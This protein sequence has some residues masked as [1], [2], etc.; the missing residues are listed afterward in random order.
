MS[1]SSLW[2][3]TKKNLK[4]LIRSKSSALIVIFA[5]LLIILILGLSYNTSAQYGLNIG[6]YSSSFTEDVTS[7]ISILEEEDFKV[8]KYETSV[9]EC[10]EDIKQGLV[11]TCVSLPESLNV[12]D[13][14]QKEV[15]FH[16][17]PSRVNLVWMI[18][19][20]VKTKFNLKSQEISKELAQNILTSFIS[21]KEGISEG[22]NNLNSIKEKALFASTSTQ[23]THDSL[24]DIDLSL[25]EDSISSDNVTLTKILKNIGESKDLIDNAISGI[26]GAGIEDDEVRNEIKS[27]LS[28]ADALLDELE[29]NE[30]T[31]IKDLISDFETKLSATQVKMT[32]ATSAIEGSSSDLDGVASKLQETVSAIDTLKESLAGI[33]TNLEEQ[34][35]TDAEIIV[36]PLTTKIERV[37]EKGT[38]LNYVFPTLLILVIMFTS[39]LLGTSL[40]MMEK[41]SP[42]FLRNF[43]L[44]VRK[45]S[46]IISIY[47]TNLIL[48]LLQIVI[49]LGISLIFLKEVLPVLP[50]ISL[51]LFIAASV[52]TFLG[53]TVG[54]LFTSEETGTLASISLGSLLLFISGVVL[55]IETISPIFRQI[56]LF[57]PFVIAEKLV[58]E[59]F[60]FN[61]P[62]QV[63][64]LDIL[65]LAGY[66][67][68]LFLIIL[69]IESV[70]H[71]RL[72]HKSM[73]HHKQLKKKH[74]EKKV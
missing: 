70:I 48:I 60:I 14:V 67:I 69:I 66:A 12:E 39:L 9:E 37:S 28:D 2:L 55:P 1:A 54:Y 65:L 25:S 4:L 35:V 16:I 32:A 41:H 74:K 5:P 8:V 6:I 10:I 73:R 13:N 30:S 7:F 43:F 27:Y 36:A 64:W 26:N 40:V 15:T 49:I 24:G 59:V 45:I 52:F 18:Q 62:L 68:V 34:K 71:N 51:V 33:Q 3:L 50:Q 72:R 44:P 21:T 46:F 20:T 17:D 19:E 47:F 11:H 42:A 23:T 31:S 53:M 58:R 29:G 22:Q 57:N 61:S 38:Y 63:I 56:T